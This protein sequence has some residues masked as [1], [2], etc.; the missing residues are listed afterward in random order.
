MLAETWRSTQGEERERILGEIWTLIILGLEKYMRAFSRRYGAQDRDEIRDIA[1]DKALDLLV[2]LDRQAWDTKAST[3]AQLCAFLASVARNGIVDHWR[4]RNREVQVSE[5]PRSG[6]DPIEQAGALLPV[7][8]G[9]PVYAGEQAQA[10]AE[11]SRRLSPRARW[12]WFLRVFYELSSVDIARHPEVAG[13]PAGVDT[14]LLRCRS[15][16]RDCMTSK[17]F[18]PGRIPVGAFT[19]LWEML[20]HERSSF[21]KGLSPADEERGPAEERSSAERNVQS[22]V[23]RQP[24][25]AARDQISVVRHQGSAAMGPISVDGRQGSATR[26]RSPAAKGEARFSVPPFEGPRS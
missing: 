26:E 4:T 9:V 11:C 18:D 25:A 19:L 17:G 14:M 12:V 23:D 2:R 22:S 3:P 21:D 1:R 7:F 15:Q 8:D 20:A 16:M 5:S 6:D 24:S 10:I 13:T